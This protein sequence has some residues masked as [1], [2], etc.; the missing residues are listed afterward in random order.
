MDMFVC[1]VVQ[2]QH[3][4]GVCNCHG[5]ALTDF[6]RQFKYRQL[7]K[8]A[9]GMASAKIDNEAV[10]MAWLAQNA[11][12]VQLSELYLAF[13]EIEQQAKNHLSAD[14]TESTL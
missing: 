4:A 2:K 8:E 3:L 10:F 5:H 6:I 12:G 9:K 14:H 13:K 1:R 11:S 7:L